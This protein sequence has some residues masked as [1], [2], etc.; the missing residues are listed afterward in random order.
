M[1]IVTDI[2][3]FVWAFI[4]GVLSISCLAL[5]MTVVRLSGDKK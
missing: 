4:T 1:E 3:I 5:G 2:I